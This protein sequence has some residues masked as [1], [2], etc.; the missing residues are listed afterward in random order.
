MK[1]VSWIKKNKL[2]TALLIIVGYLFFG[3]LV[4]SFFGV[5]LLN[6]SVPSSQYGSTSDY[7]S[8]ATGMPAMEKAFAPSSYSVP[9]R[10]YT[11]QPDVENRLVIQESHLSLLVKDV[12]DTRDKILTHTNTNG[13]YMVN[14]ST[15]NPQDAPTATVVIRI[16]SGKLQTTLDYF[17]SLSIKVVSENLVGRD[18][19]DQYV[20]IDTRIATYEKT[21]AKFE[22]ILDQ[23]TKI[24]DIANLTQQIISTQ[25]QIDSLKGQ[26]D[27]LE[28]K[29]QMAKLTIYLSTDEMALPYTP[30]ETFRPKVIFKLAVRSLIGF[31]RKFASLA[32]WVGVYSIV[33]VPTLAIY[34]LLRKWLARRKTETKP[35]SI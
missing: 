15:S 10:D 21:K 2:A 16:P 26:Q 12:V 33:W 17:H 14:S 35:T 11:P 30:S 25:N 18:V 20:N 27:A 7:V 3:S 31:L 6:M 24:S 1:I 9:S 29:A 34:I 28:K 23:A 13:G 4:K 19:T 22:S 5:S 32:I 8:N